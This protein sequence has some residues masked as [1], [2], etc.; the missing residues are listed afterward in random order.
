MAVAAV[1][2]IYAG[3]A[4]GLFAAAI[5]SVQL[6]FFRGGEV[7]AAVLG[8]DP[9]WSALLRGRLAAAHWHLEFAALAA[10]L[11]VAAVALE[12]LA[13][14]FEARRLRSVALA[15]AFGL[16]LYYPLVLLVTFN[17]AF[18]ETEG[19]LYAMLLQA[20]RWTWLVA[21][22]LGA[23]AAAL[24]VR[25]VSP[26]SGGHGV[27]EV[28]EA[29]HVR[30]VSI[31]GRVAVWKSLAA[32]LVIGSG[33]SAGREGP[34]VHLGGAVASSLSRTLELPHK[35]AALLLACGAGAGIA[36]SFRAPLA[37]ALFAL[38]IVLGDF[39]V[40][41]FT[42]IVLACVTATATSRALLAVGSDLRPI[43]W[44]LTHPTEIGVYLV[45][46]IVAGFCGVLYA[47]VI[48]GAE[49]AF[50]RL[51]R[52]RPEMRAALGGLIVGAVGLVAPRALGTGIETLNAALGG[53]LALGALVLALVCKLIATS[54]TLGSGSPGG[55]FFPAAFI[56]AMLGG[57]FGRIAQAA[58]PGIVS[59]AEAYAAVGMGAVV[60]GAT[61]APLT[62]VLMM[63]ELTGS[64]QIVLPL[65]VACGVSAAICNGVLGGSMYLLAARRRGVRLARSG[66]A[67]GDLS[68]AQ[69]MEKAPA[70]AHD[71]SLARLAADLI[72][73]TP[74][75]AFPVVE[76]GKVVGIVSAREAREALLDPSTDHNA[77]LSALVREVPVFLPDDDLET[78]SHKLTDAGS[79]E[80]LVV[81]EDQALGVI[82][83]Q[84][85]LEAWRRAM[86][87]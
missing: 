2:G 56:G 44:S 69:A 74:Y 8:E 73:V 52:W 7:L 87:E 4:A 14:R 54:A 47:R 9:Q 66:P 25:Y 84:R 27:V 51:K 31:R 42:P 55:S 70:I 33:G 78:A 57:A 13:P 65:L 11:L 83:Q 75:A 50:G 24:L 58:L 80:G 46:G 18:H 5:R 20:P 77:P 39:A 29:V 6:V 49:I 35:E 22:T 17:G 79:T 41:R 40:H 63:F 21:P 62:G 43:A 36:A 32:G 60:A 26:E 23:L 76:D 34:V 45:L 28:I 71:L 67:L 53:Q 81:E 72:A 64:Y 37:G 16:V 68:V 86:A 85:I 3:I 1:V 82:T 10:L 48:H 30:G 12:A 61:V 19:G 15:G 59:G 38:E